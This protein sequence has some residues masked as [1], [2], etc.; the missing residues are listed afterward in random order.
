[1]SSLAEEPCAN[2]DSSDF[3]L[4]AKSFGAEIATEVSKFTTHVIANPDRKTTKVKTAARYPHIHIVNADWMF[5]S[6]T[7]WERADEKPYLIALDDADRSG[8]P[9]EED[10]S[11]N[12]SGDEDGAEPAESPIAID[13]SDDQWK[14]MGDELDD[15]LNE[16]DGTEDASA[17]E[18][19]SGVSTNGT[20]KRK[21]KRETDSV[22]NSE[23]EESDTSVNSASKLQRRKR[24]TMERV[25]SLNT[26]VNADKSSGLP[27][28]ETTGPEE[29]Q[30][31]DDGKLFD[32][33]GQ[34]ADLDEVDY[35]DG[36]EA[37]MLAEFEKSGSE[38]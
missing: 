19:E 11:L 13:M 29:E 25:T 37:E 31:E 14:S 38:E 30:G 10:D 5:Q 34:G 16:S 15:F 6:C 22:D 8:S 26:V 7:Q 9:F 2:R 21:R 12:V 3:A 32:A 1:M 27:S 17:S 24:R 20:S 28:P 23:D 36:F 35:D 18:S 33:Q 4:W